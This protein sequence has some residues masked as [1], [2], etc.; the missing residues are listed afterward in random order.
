MTREI[1]RIDEPQ[2]KRITRLARQIY[3][4]LARYARKEDDEGKREEE[5]EV[6]TTFVPRS[7]FRN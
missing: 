6:N 3:E 4:K 1:Q 2:L 5:E 7:F